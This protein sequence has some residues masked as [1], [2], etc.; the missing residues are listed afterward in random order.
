MIYLGADHR[1]FELKK[2]LI[3]KLKNKN[4]EFIDLG[5]YEYNKEDDYPLIAFKVAKEV[6]KD[7]NNR[8]IILC[9]SGIGVCIAAN[10]IKGIRAA[11][12]LNIEIIKKGREDDDINILCIPADFID[13]EKAWDIIEV[14]LNTKFKKEEKYLRRIK[15]LDDFK[16]ELI[17]IED[18]NKIDLRIGKIENVEVIEGTKL[19]KLSV[20]IG[21]EKR[22][23]VAGIGLKY[24]PQ[25]LNGQL[26]IIVAN[27][28]PKIIKG[29]E[30]QGMLLAASSEEGPV[31]IVPLEQVEVGS[32]VR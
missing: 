29:I 17:D 3:E 14:F 20:N 22:N 23:I 27:L 5:A 25:D 13:K 26:I 31:I 11:S 9:G 18:F 24:T 30:S 4:L 10:R 8:G 1:G 16:E 2:Y 12:S 7:K 6:V 32:R 15:E 19:V 28:K 21:S